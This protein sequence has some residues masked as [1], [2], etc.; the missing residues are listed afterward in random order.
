MSEPEIVVDTRGLACPLPVLKLRKALS[1]RAPG[2]R[3]TL[4]ATDPQADRD[5]PAYCTEAGHRLLAQTTDPAGV[6][7]FVVE[8]G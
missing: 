4:V 7:R 6:T 1:T 3:V 2:A 5:V 8:R